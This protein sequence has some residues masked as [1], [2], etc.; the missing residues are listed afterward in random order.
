MI[1][2]HVQ[3]RNA[4]FVWRLNILGEVLRNI[5]EHDK[6]ASYATPAGAAYACDLVK[7]FIREKYGVRSTK[8]ELSLPQEK[9]EDTALR[10]GLDL[11]DLSAVFDALPWR[12]REFC[13]D[14]GPLLKLQGD[15]D[16]SR[17]VP[18]GNTNYLRTLLGAL[19]HRLTDGLKILQ[20]ASQLNALS[21]EKKSAISALETRLSELEIETRAEVERILAIP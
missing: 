3:Q 11:K 9:F 19:P 13:L 5:D 2:R 20:K 8:T 16:A 12:A 4:R 17:V 7:F 15:R 10:A 14:A 21:D 6:E 1:F 18:A